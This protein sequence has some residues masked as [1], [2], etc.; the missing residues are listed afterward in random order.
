M[1]VCG[2]R[3]TQVQRARALFHTFDVILALPLVDL[4]LLNPIVLRTKSCHHRLTQ[5]MGQRRE[6]ES[7]PVLILKKRSYAGNAEE[8]SSHPL[9]HVH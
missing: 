9:L 4:V 5:L 2:P 6:A 3:G 8:N 1:S 7:H